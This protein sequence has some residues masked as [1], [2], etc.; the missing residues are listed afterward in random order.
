MTRDELHFLFKQYL[1][2]NF[3][4]IEW[5]FHGNKNKNAFEKELSTCEEY[6]KLINENNNGIKVAI[7]LSGH[8]RKNSMLNGIEK[9]CKN[10]NFHIFIHTWDTI[11][12]KGK[13]TSF[14]DKI[15][16]N[17]I[18]NQIN[19]YKNL[20]KYEIENNESWIKSQKIGSNYFNL[21]SPEIFIKSQL[22]SINRSY[23]LM[24]EYSNENNINYDIVLKF[25]FDCDLISFNLTD[26]LI[27]DIKN[28]DIIFTPNLDCKHSHMDHGTSCWACD[29]M[30]YKYDRKIVHIFEHTN[31][32]CDL[33]A[34]GNKN[35][36]KKYCDLYNNYDTLTDSFFEENLKQYEKI[37]QYI[38]HENGNYI[39]EQNRNGHIDS[40]YYYY[41][42]YPERLLQKFLKEYMLV[43]SKEIKVKFIR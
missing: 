25:R 11:G 17:N 19:K 39:I 38:K 37:N 5:K 43:E 3:T 41:C 35:S 20:K 34:Y 10:Q 1:N 15:E 6:L 23:N 32:V 24:E 18:I 26:K 33:F 36:M 21:S 29:N 22:Y 30:Y 2:R 14:Q 16:T 7:L 9:F 28:H 13:E 4:E 42:S 27:S 12:I 8:I 31:I 40:L